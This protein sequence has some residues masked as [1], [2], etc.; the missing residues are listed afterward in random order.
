MVRSQAG[1]FPSGK[2]VASKSKLSYNDQLKSLFS[3]NFDC[4]SQCLS[5][6][7]FPWFEPDS[8]SKAI[9][10]THNGL[11]VEDDAHSEAILVDPKPIHTRLFYSGKKMI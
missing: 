1:R 8:C 6:G 5:H 3:D 9:L 10:E 4:S 11:T 2:K 7:N